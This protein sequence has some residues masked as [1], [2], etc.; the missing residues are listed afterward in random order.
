MDF[1]HNLIE[2]FLKSY[3]RQVDGRM[4]NP[5][6][7]FS[8][9]FFH[10]FSVLTRITS[11]LLPLS[12]LLSFLEHHFLLRPPREHDCSIRFHWFTVVVR[13]GRN[14]EEPSLGGDFPEILAKSRTW[15]GSFYE[16]DLLHRDQA[17][18]ILFERDS[19]RLERRFKLSPVVIV[20]GNENEKDLTFLRWGCTT[21][22]PTNF[23]SRNTS[24]PYLSSSVSSLPPPA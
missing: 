15:H 10:P 5:P 21:S 9:K 18:D 23:S 4:R 14:N 22:S 8:S 12:F 2:I 7:I 16:G 17:L 11:M 3:A 6:T 1:S 24:R 13:R 20:A 19:S